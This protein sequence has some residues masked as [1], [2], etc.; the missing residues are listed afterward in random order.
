MK[1]HEEL[2][3]LEVDRSVKEIVARFKYLHSKFKY[4]NTLFL[5][6]EAF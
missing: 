2:E 1:I 4:I 5:S 6:E 3:K